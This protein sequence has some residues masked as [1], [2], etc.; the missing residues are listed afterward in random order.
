M[1]F[2]I[3]ETILGFGIAI[4]LVLFVIFGI[5]AFTDEPMHE[6]FCNS[7]VYFEK[8]YPY[9]AREPYREINYTLCNKAELK[10]Y[11]F[12]RECIGKKG[13]VI[14]EPDENGCRTARECSLCQRDFDSARNVY[15]KNVFIITGAIGIIVIIIGALLELT[16]VGAGL[17]GGGILLVIVAVIRYWSSLA[18]WAR[19]IILG[20]VLAVLI[21]VGYTKLKK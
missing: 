20:I 12:E 4:V 11:E 21:W 17:F 2:K 5:K 9:P 7:T 14:Y 19:F 15:N 8:P 16:S 18:D 3:K 13:S 6:D 1:P 10:N